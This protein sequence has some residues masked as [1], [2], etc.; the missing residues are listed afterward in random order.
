MLGAK[1][2]EGAKVALTRPFE[3]A[4]D[5]LVMD[6][7]HVGGDD[8]HPGGFHFEDFVFPLGA[9]VTRKVKFSGYGKPGFS[10]EGEKTVVQ[11][12]GES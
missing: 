8:V 11:A 7:D 12:E 5:L 6:P 10:V 1:L 4:L 9:R 3:L 2:G